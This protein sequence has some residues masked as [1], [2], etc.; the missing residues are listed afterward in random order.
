MRQL[1]HHAGAPPVL[2]LNAVASL[3]TLAW[4][5]GP[6]VA[7]V[8]LRRTRVWWVPGVVAIAGVIVWLAVPHE[9]RRTVDEAGPDVGLLMELAFVVAVG[10]LW[11]VVLVFG[12]FATKEPSKDHLDDRED[13][14]L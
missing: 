13:R 7:T 10:V 4:L 9:G 1:Q 3:L 2:R 6:V 11:L 8:A 14:A 5:F 12:A